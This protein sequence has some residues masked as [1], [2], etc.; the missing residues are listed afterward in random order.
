VPPFDLRLTFL[1][2]RIGL[3]VTYALNI[4]RHRGNRAT[5]VHCMMD[6][7]MLERDLPGSELHMSPARSKTTNRV[8]TEA[9]YYSGEGYVFRYIFKDKGLITVLDLFDCGSYVPTLFA[10]SKNTPSINC[11]SRDPCDLYC[12]SLR[13]MKCTSRII[14]I[15]IVRPRLIEPLAFLSAQYGRP[16]HR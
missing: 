7:G 11:S 1:V 14:H 9:G 6:A 8:P 12:T 3:F 16:R 2:T 10:I 5:T 15:F 13:L 4:I